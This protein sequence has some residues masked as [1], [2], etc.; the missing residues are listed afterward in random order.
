[1]TRLKTRIPRPIPPD[2]NRTYDQII[3]FLIGLFF[4]WLSGL[5]VCMLGGMR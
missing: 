4:G 3:I 2:R 5:L 1:M